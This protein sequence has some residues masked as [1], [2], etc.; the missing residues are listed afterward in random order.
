MLR[1]TTILK[2]KSLSLPDLVSFIFRW[3]SLWRWLWDV[4]QWTLGSSSRDAG[5]VHRGGQWTATRS[6]TPLSSCHMHPRHQRALCTLPLLF[7][8]LFIRG[9]YV[10]NSS[11]FYR[12]RCSLA[13]VSKHA[14]NMHG[15]CNFS[16][17]K[18]FTRLSSLNL[19]IFDSSSLD[20][21]ISSD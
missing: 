19:R 10:D 9:K 13:T 18:F 12:T 4:A 16:T 20:E 14:S 5:Y 17:R 6:S 1:V 21:W 15:H 11:L 7:L 8:V 3:A 2:S